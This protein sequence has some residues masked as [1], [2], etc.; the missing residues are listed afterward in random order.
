MTRIACLKATLGL[1]PVNPTTLFNPFRG[2]YYG[3]RNWRNLHISFRRRVWRLFLS[4]LCYELIL[5]PR[6][7]S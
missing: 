7:M 2:Q 6:F 3:P 4:N 5:R 1:D